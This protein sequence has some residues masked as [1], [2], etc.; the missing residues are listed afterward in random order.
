MKTPF[1]LLLCLPLLAGCSDSAKSVTAPTQAAG[2]AKDAFADLN[3]PSPPNQ[4]AKQV[5]ELE[6]RI[7]TLEGTLAAVETHLAR[8]A[9]HDRPVPL[10]PAGKGYSKVETDL[11]AL[12]V[13]AEDIQPYLDGY[14][15][16]CVIG[17]PG[18][19]DHVACKV[20]LTWGPAFDSTLIGTNFETYLD[21]W[22][23][24]QRTNTTAILTPLVAGAWSPVE[25]IIAPAKADEL[26]NLEV[27]I[28]ST[29]ISLRNVKPGNR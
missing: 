21:H 16:K 3:P 5:A 19:G 9:N 17:N 6:K 11:G 12:L 8:M 10:N 20:T 29:Q 28:E 24:Q 27:Q 14:K 2:S 25:L 23:G 18:A 4:L 1:L 26:R 22:K 13:M 15:L 7:D